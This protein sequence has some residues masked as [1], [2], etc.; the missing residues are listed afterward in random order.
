MGAGLFALPYIVR[1]AGWG[2]SLFYLFLVSVLIMFVHS[3]YWRILQGSRGERLLNL[4]KREG[5]N[6]FFFLAFLSIVPGLLLVLVAYLILAGSFTA[7][8]FPQLD[9]T[10]GSIIF[11]LIGSSP[12]LF[13]VRRLV[14][15]EFFGGAVIAAIIIFLFGSAFFAFSVR[16]EVP[17]LTADFLLPFGPFL[18][19]LA[20][21]TAIEPAHDAENGKKS[22]SA[23]RGLA[24]GTI[25]SVILYAIFVLAVF[26]LAQEI[27]PDAVSGLS[28]LPAWQLSLLG[29]LGL[30]L[31]IT[32]YIPI[33]WEVKTAIQE[34]WP[35]WSSS[36]LIITL[37]LPIG[38]FFLGLNNFLSVISLVGGFFLSLQYLFILFVA[39]RVL[40]LKT[41]E[42]VLIVSGS[43]IFVLAAFYEGFV[44]LLR[45]FG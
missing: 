43:L 15:L 9:R 16:P 41:N 39:W 34:V 6:N 4:V 42:K 8:F 22:K 37:V 1:Q 45:N 33:A 10:V 36:G 35:S 13:G 38:L 5:G 18:F 32:S 14:S 24:W 31:L 26:L 3:L 19:A 25:F 29:G 7:L 20:G 21:W 30:V 17:F 28:H 12:L 11:W 2:T 40:S 44:F 27:F 23:F